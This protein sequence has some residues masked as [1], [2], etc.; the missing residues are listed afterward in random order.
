MKISIDTNATAP[1]KKRFRAQM[2]AQA[3]IAPGNT[4]RGLVATDLEGTLQLHAWDVQ[5]GTLSSRTAFPAGIRRGFLSP[6]GRWIYYHHDNRGDEIGY[7]Y[8]IPWAGGTAVNVTPEMPEYAM[9]TC[10][11]SL[12]GQLLS[13]THADKEGFHIQVREIHG[14]RRFTVDKTTIS[15]GMDFS[16]DGRL[17][18]LATTEQSGSVDFNLEV[19]DMETGTR[20]AEIWDGVGTSM[21]SAMFSPVAGDERLLATTNNGGYAR[22]FLWNPRTGERTPIGLGE[23]SGEVVPLD[24]SN[25]GQRILLTIVEHALFR[26]FVCDLPSSK[27]IEVE[28]DGGS[29]LSAQFLQEDVVLL[30]NDSAHPWRVIRRSVS[31]GNTRTLLRGNDVPRSPKWTSVSFTGAREESVH[32]WIATPPGEGPFATVVHTHGGPSSVTTDLYY[33]A[34]SAWLD[35]GFAFCSIN[36]H[37]STTFGADFKN[38]INGNLGDL[39][40]RD[41]A[42]GVEWLVDKGIANPNLLFKTGASYGGYLTLLTCG[43]YPGLFA[44]GIAVVAV[45]D[46]TIMYEDEADTLRGY[47]RAL[48]GGSPDEKPAEHRK[49]SPLT[50]VDQLE[51]PLLVIQG[52]NDTRC[53]SRQMEVYVQTARKAGKSIEIQWFEAGHLSL[54]TARRIDD[55]EASMLFAAQIINR[56][57]DQ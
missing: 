54:D 2:I 45:A 50:Y 22:P 29:V 28:H 17:G 37:G 27:V 5:T 16:A 36:Y 26:L 19:Y 13:L 4:E 18:V 11:E 6:N 40:T 34:A 9:L 7:L 41:I 49:A 32:A 23:L 24:W 47:Q 12:D 57:R 42:A 31:G 3:V 1:W 44:G 55:Q 53:P 38:S 8:R 46:W 20:I 56:R 35:H 14:P 21:H 52:R 30:T 10:T 33:P 48:F 39:E 51:A 15:A 43:K 25:D